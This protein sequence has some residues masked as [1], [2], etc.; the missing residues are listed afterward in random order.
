MRQL[1]TKTCKNC[2]Q[3]LPLD[4]YYPHPYTKDKRTALCKECH[5]ASVRA[6]RQQNSEYFRE[7]DRQRAFTPERVAARKAY[8]DAMRD[9][10]E[11]VARQRARAKFWSDKNMVKRRAQVMAGNAIRDK[12]LVRPKVCERCGLPGEKIHAHHENYYKPLDV[13]WLCIPCHGIR[14]REINEAIRSGEDWKCR[15]FE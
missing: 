12:K 11:F 2:E 8:Q 15:G 7:Y 9:D 3:D 13:T 14:H 1:T 6:H 5:K 4:K 10:P